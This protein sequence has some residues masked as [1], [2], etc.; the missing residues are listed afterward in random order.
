MTRYDAVLF[1]NDGVLVEP[2]LYDSKVAA[3]TDAFR[4]MGVGD[5]DA[6]HVDAIVSGVTIETVYEVCEIY[7]IDAEA[8]WDAR[9]RHDERVQ[10][11]DFR[12][13]TR[14]CY[15]D[16]TAFGEL[17]QPCGVVSNNHHSTVEFVLEY[18]ELD[19]FFE[20]YHGREMAIE[21]LDLKKPGTHY[22][23]EAIADLGCESPLFVGDREL[24]VVAAHRAGLD[25]VFVRRPH[26]EE[27]ALLTTPTYEVDDLHGVVDV[28]R[29]GDVNY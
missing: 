3:V 11:D 20:T 7:D 23:G 5:V 2:P 15:G 26:T 1:D 24:D 9:E 4:E 17:S 13:G 19:A 25:S 21:S 29:K 16:V 6:T 28:A 22:V 27:V 12:E 14:R 10:R 18:F 8:F